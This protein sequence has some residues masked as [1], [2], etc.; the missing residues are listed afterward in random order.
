MGCIQ[1]PADAVLLPWAKLEV[2]S[3]QAIAGL[4]LC[5]S[6]ISTLAFQGGAAVM[7]GPECY[8]CILCKART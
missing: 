2:K 5:I 4:P 7:A 3:E 6:S 8:C 1:L